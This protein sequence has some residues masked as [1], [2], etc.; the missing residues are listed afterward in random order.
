MNCQADFPETWLRG[1]AWAKA[2]KF[3]TGCGSRKLDFSLSWRLHGGGLH[4]ECPSYICGM[5]ALK[6]ITHT[7]A[8]ET[9]LMLTSLVYET[10]LTNGMGPVLHV[11]VYVC[12]C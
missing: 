9:G 7:L 12:A 2:L 5:F 10:Y 3:R 4:S 11:C 1:G 8:L 6:T